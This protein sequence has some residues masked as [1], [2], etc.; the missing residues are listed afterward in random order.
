M[1]RF[2]HVVCNS[3]ERPQGQCLGSFF[4][5]PFLPLVR[6]DE[7]ISGWRGSGQLFRRPETNKNL[8]FFDTID[9]MSCFSCPLIHLPYPPPSP[10]H[11]HIVFCLFSGTTLIFSFLFRDVRKKQAKSNV[12]SSLP[13][14]K[15]FVLVD[16][17]RR[18]KKS[19]TCLTGASQHS[20]LPKYRFRAL[21][22]AGNGCRR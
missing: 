15:V 8:P 16:V 6:A 22:H 13:H 18:D 19:G 7:R 21:C 12:G 9:A 20:I 3:N 10:G 17:R 2:L 1:W 4:Y 14:R 5:C 11:V